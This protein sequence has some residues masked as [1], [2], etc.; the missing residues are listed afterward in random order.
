MP[1]KK[2]LKMINTDCAHFHVTLGR[3]PLQT[4]LAELSEN[5]WNHWKGLPVARVIVTLLPDR[6]FS[7]MLHTKAGDLI[8]FQFRDFQKKITESATSRPPKPAAS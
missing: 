5:L 1:I 3:G 6:S 8:E 2:T 7:I 4:Y